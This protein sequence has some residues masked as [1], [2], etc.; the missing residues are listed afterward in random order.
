M[1][2]S[3]SLYVDISIRTS[4][5]EIRKRLKKVKPLRSLLITPMLCERTVAAIRN[6]TVD[7][8]QQNEIGIVAYRFLQNKEG[9]KNTFCKAVFFGTCATIYIVGLCFSPASL[10]LCIALVLAL[11]NTI[12]NIG[13]TIRYRETRM[14]CEDW[15]APKVG[16]EFKKIKELKFN[17]TGLTEL[18]D[19]LKTKQI[20]T[21]F[22]ENKSSQLK[23]CG[24]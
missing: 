3:G 11:A 15:L 6:K 12:P 14:A 10:L 4:D 8:I 13:N 24:C 16:E 17:K 21:T 9:E 7:N 18:S 20:D 5:K 2:A 1:S 19:I 23:Q 22:I